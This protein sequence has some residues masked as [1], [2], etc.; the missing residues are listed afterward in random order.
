MRVT[1]CLSGRGLLRPSAAVVLGLTARR[2]GR[3]VARAV[4]DLAESW[5][6]GVPRLVVMDRGEVRAA[7]TARP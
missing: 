3:S 4:D 6:A 2:I 5:N 7:L 1:V